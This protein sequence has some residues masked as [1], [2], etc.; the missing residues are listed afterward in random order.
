M[1]SWVAADARRRSE[2][3]ACDV[4]DFTAV[5]LGKYVVIAG[6]VVGVTVRTGVGSDPG[7]IG[8]FGRLFVPL[9]FIAGLLLGF[10]WLWPR[11]VRWWPRTPRMPPAPQPRF[12]VDGVPWVAMAAGM[13]AILLPLSV[14]LAGMMAAAY[15]GVWLLL[16]GLR[17]RVGDEERCACCGYLVTTPRWYRGLCPECGADLDRRWGIVLGRDRRSVWR[18][19]AG[20]L[21]IAGGVVWGTVG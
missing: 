11:L 21:L 9:T 2:R 14:R 7:L 19:L 4:A 20:V 8:L 12:R 18:V 15:L 5:V 3:G 16:T 10:W 1:A 17:R 13:L 6:L